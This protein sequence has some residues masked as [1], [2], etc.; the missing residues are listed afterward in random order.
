MG[1]EDNGDEEWS[2]KRKKGMVEGRVV[3]VEGEENG[4]G[5][6][7]KDL[8]FGFKFFFYFELLG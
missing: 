5:G 2:E 3:V 8:G 1:G 4:N 7:R 6:C